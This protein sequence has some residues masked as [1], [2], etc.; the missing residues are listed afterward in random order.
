MP[1]EDTTA[2][3]RCR[4][5]ADADFGGEGDRA[6]SDAVLDALATA[7]GVDPLD[8]PPL[9]E[10][11]DPDALDRLFRRAEDDD[12]DLLV[13]FGVDDWNVFVRGDGRVRVCD[14]T[15]STRATRVFGPTEA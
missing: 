1:T 12:A 5:V 6:P 4:P 2:A 8:L 9:Y 13:E 3:C 7:T 15:K 11:I 14:A 10:R